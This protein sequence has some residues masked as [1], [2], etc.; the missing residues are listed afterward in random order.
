MSLPYESNI[1]P[2]GLVRIGFPMRLVA[3]LIDGLIVG[4]VVMLISVV[5]VRILGARVAVIL[6]TAIILA[7]FSLEILHGQSVGKKISPLK[8]DRRR[9]KIS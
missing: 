8:A 1:N 7:Y 3:A 5:A 4:V 2:S 6:Q 9:R